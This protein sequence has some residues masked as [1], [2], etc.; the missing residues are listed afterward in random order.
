MMD[1]DFATVT[2]TMT[3]NGVLVPPIVQGAKCATLIMR[4]K[5]GH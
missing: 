1:G 2:K 3:K 4:P 5:D